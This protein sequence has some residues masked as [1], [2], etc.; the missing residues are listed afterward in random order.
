M[1]QCK[2]FSMPYCEYNKQ[3]PSI[4]IYILHSVP[5]LLKLGL[6]I[7]LPSVTNLDLCFKAAKCL[8]YKSHMS[9]YGAVTCRGGDMKKVTA[10]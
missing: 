10:F 6:Y 1:S 4:F 9:L 2:D 8:E 3:L 5:A 7:H